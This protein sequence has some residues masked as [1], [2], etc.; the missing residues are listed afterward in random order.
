M[1][2]DD[3]LYILEDVGNVVTE[4]D[5]FWNQRAASSTDCLCGENELDLEVLSAAKM[6]AQTRR[7][8]FL[9]TVS[10]A[11]DEHVARFSWKA[12]PSVVWAIFR[13]QCPWLVL[14]RQSL[15][16][17]VSVLVLLLMVETYGSL[18][19]VTVLFQASGDTLSV[20][21]SEECTVEGVFASFGATIAISGF[22]KVAARYP[23]KLLALLPSREFVLL[24]SQHVDAWQTQLLTWRRRSR[25]LWM[26]GAMYVTAA[27]I[28]IAIFLASVAPATASAWM[29][30]ALATVLMNALL[31]PLLVAVGT[32]TMGAACTCCLNQSQMR[33]CGSDFSQTAEEKAP[34]GPA[35]L[36]GVVASQ[37]ANKKA[38]ESGP[39][40]LL[41]IVPELCPAAVSSSYMDALVHTCS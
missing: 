24:P 26:L 14:T 37:E 40:G 23:R 32:A 16:C 15:R 27:A 35:T 19:V 30:K 1:T 6:W 20:H 28:V 12:L 9:H 17:P 29:E 4:H 36:L 41:G 18:L 38:M 8:P 22:T 2:A 3:V 10:A 21:S 31:F 13:S 11:L 25:L 39:P 34:T 7:Q 33:R 5:E